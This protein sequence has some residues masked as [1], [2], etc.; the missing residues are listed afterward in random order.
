M[1][2]SDYMDSFLA[3]INADGCRIRAKINGKCHCPDLPFRKESDILI[4]S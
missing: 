1:G 2:F 3:T 4:F